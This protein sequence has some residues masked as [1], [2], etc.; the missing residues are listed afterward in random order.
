[1]LLQPLF[2]TPPFSNTDIEKLTLIV[3]YFINNRFVFCEAF[4]P[5]RIKLRTLFPWHDM[6]FLRVLT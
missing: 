5:F 4:N 1:M 2:Y 3:L 6:F